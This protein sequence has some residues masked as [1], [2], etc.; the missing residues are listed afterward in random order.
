VGA[1]NGVRWVPVR[2][3]LRAKMCRVN[4]PAGEQHMT[5]LKYDPENDA[6]WRKILQETHWTPLAWLPAEPRC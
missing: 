1:E 4:S 3:A 2:L 6:E 5:E